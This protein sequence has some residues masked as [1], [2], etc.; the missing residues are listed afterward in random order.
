[1]NWVQYNLVYDIKAYLAQLFIFKIFKMNLKLE[2]Q[3]YKTNQKSISS[4]RIEFSRQQYTIIFTIKH[5]NF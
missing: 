1:M 5:T 4:S 3:S 2:K